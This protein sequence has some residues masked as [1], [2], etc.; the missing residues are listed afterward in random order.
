MESTWTTEQD[1]PLQKILTSVNGGSQSQRGG[2]VNG[3]FV[4]KADRAAR[5]WMEH[6]AHDD[7]WECVRLGDGA[8]RS[9]G[10]CYCETK[11]SSGA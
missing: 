11:P 4:N 10:A 1:R 3:C 5:Q 7:A 2:K 8:C 6:G 9:V